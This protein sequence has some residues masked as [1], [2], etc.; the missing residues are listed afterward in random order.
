MKYRHEMPFGSTLLLPEDCEFALWAPA[1]KQVKL[2]ADGQAYE[3]DSADRG[4]WR[5]RVDLPAGTR[6]QWLI[7]GDSRVP[8]PASRRNPQ[9]PH[10]PSEVVDPRHFHW[11]VSWKGR[12]WHETVAYQVHIGTFTEEGT[13]AAAIEKLSSLAELGVTAIQLMP[14]ASFGG[15]FGWGYDNVLLYAPNEVY[16]TPDDLKAFV[17]AAHC[18]GLMVFLDVV[19][20]H[21]GPDGN[22]L[23]RYAPQFESSQHETPWGK[24]MNFDGDGATE[25]REFMIQNALYWLEEFQ[26]DGLRLDAV[27][28][29]I[30]DSP[31]HV[32]EELTRRAH[33][34]FAERHVHIILENDHNNPER[35][36]LPTQSAEG[37]W[38]G[39][40]H[41]CLH[42]LITGE[43]KSYYAEYVDDPVGRLGRVLTLGFSRDGAEEPRADRSPRRD[44]TSTISLLNSVNFLQCHD[45]IGNRAFGERLC[46]LGAPEALRLASA[47]LLLSPPIPMLFMGEE[48]ASRRPFLYFAD[49]KP[50]QREAVR[51]GRRK[52]FRD[53]PDADKV[54]SREPPDPCSRDTFLAS[55]IEPA[56]SLDGEQRTTLEWTKHLL[57]LRHR[58]VVPHLPRLK[59]G[60]H[61]AK[62]LG[63]TGLALRWHF[64]D[65]RILEAWIN[66]GN[67]PVPLDCAHQTGLASD[68]LIEVGEV[69][70][71]SLGA[72]SGTWFWNS[73]PG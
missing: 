7:D 20:N 45:Q 53:A 65:G 29:M 24:A 40:F 28:A 54:Q 67:V 38:N 9:G 15:A 37:Q 44:A 17:D 70:K 1:A 52:E 5:V 36:G 49:A 43:T 61:E 60:V 63:A 4:W 56:G 2:L 46:A 27:H 6:Y 64:D 34:A 51:V 32:V 50:E 11:Q 26:F 8:D 41:H 21:L 39:D 16:G 22:F 10:R 71:T 14:V 48:H 30:D 31:T 19:Y 58:E 23:P 73:R 57:D 18:Q 68:P 13:F 69:D 42:V 35:I 47:L 62:R 25:V 72:W 66:L 3:C 33:A 55:V 12:P 59:V